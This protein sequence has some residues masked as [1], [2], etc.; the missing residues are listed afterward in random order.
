M[1]RAI[2]NFAFDVLKFNSKIV[3]Y[4]GPLDTFIDNSKHQFIYQNEMLPQYEHIWITRK[5]EII[6][7]LRSKGLKA[8]KSTSLIGIWKQLR[9]KIII[10]DIGIQF[11]DVRLIH[12]VHA[13]E[14]YHGIPLKK[15]LYARLTNE[16]PDKEFIPQTRE[17]KYFAASYSFLNPTKGLDNVYSFTFRV[18][19]SNFIY[20]NFPRNRVLLMDK[21]KREK[22]IEKYE[23]E[24]LKKFYYEIEKNSNEKIIYMPTFRDGNPDFMNQAIPDFNKLNEVCKKAN[25]T[26]YIKPHRVASPLDVEGLSNVKIINGL[27]DIY[28]ALPLF[29]VLIS[30]YSSIMFDYS[31]MCKNIFTYNFDERQYNDESRSLYPHYYVLKKSLTNVNN[32]EDLLCLLGK[33]ERNL[34]PFPTEDFFFDIHEFNAVSEFT[35]KYLG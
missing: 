4:G 30:D 13:I 12:R 24:D 19:K 28:P 11:T 15:V 16:A 32:F 31:I 21:G 35:K 33:K 8:Y 9:A 20:Q 1:A 18:P 22:F 2:L 3:L 23:T 14:L 26:F 27:I 17:E 25:I 10:T 34:M 6:D 7:F 5:K 29:D